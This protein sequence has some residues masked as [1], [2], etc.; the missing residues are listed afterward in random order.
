MELSEEAA[1]YLESRAIPVEVAAANG[2]GTWNGNLCF[3]YK[4]NGLLQYRKVRFV[5]DQGVKSFGRDRKGAETCLFLE[6]LIES[7][8]DLSS[9]LVV[10]E[11][12]IDALSLAACGIPNVISVPDGAQLDAE[13]EGKID[14]T[15]DKAFS[16]L[17]QGADL[18]PHLQQFDRVILATDNDKKGRVLRAE[19]AVRFGTERCYWV[20]FPDGCKDA[21]DVLVKHGAEALAGL[22]ATA[23]PIIPNKL[24]PF[25]DI[26][27]LG[28]G[29]LYSSGF[30][31]LDEGLE[32]NLVLPELVIATGDPGSGKSEFTTILAANL[33]NYHELPG[34]I[35]QFEDATTRVRET[36]TTYAMSNV[37][38]IDNRGQAK[39]WI[40]KWFRTIEPQQ[41]LEPG[42]DYTLDWLEAR[43]K[44]ART[45]HGCRW[46]LIDPW[47][48]VEHAFDKGMTEAA[49]TNNALRRIKRLSRAY[50]IAIFIVVHPSM[51]GGRLKEIEEKDGYMINGGA[52]WNNKADHLFIIDRPDKSKP[53]MYCKL[54]KSK[55]HQLMGRPGIVRME[56]RPASAK[57]MY[58]GMGKG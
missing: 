2:V 40:D 22:I 52:A 56:Y 38:G 53:A 46:V 54:A 29:E 50:Q 51:A 18:K 55:N 23:K 12:E 15:S 4:R 10:T 30:K 35:L 32:F 1:T 5:D 49:Y 7:D 48:E 44:E 6:H 14:P 39:E 13:G 45:R 20:K 43:I 28:T 25:G 58:V 36:L 11:G 8:A 9:P 17:W 31:G 26:P 27:N 21:N 37:N 47:N 42:D 41:G 19:L 16:W 3:E 34:A 57:F 33:A 24:V